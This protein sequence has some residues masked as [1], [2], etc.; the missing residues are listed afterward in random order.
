[1]MAFLKQRCVEWAQ[2][3]F[4]TNYL[5]FAYKDGRAWLSDAPSAAFLRWVRGEDWNQDDAFL[6]TTMRA[7]AITTRSPARL[8]ASGYHVHHSW[9]GQAKGFVVQGHPP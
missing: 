8:S 7:Q 6:C 9:P 1:M 2:D 3:V 4:L 5:L